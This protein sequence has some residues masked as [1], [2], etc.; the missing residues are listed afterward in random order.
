MSEENT[1]RGKRFIALA[2]CAQAGQVED[3]I[4]AQFAAIEAYGRE[5]GM[6]CVDQIT[7]GGVSPSITEDTLGELIERKQERDDFDVLLV[8]DW[9]RFSCS[10]PVR[11]LLVV[12]GLSLVGVQ[13]VSLQDGSKERADDGIHG[14]VAGGRQ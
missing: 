5:E 11:R 8:W 13:I 12:Y 3:G 1:L 4:E 7:L 9:S 10:G 6:T 14:V 2:R